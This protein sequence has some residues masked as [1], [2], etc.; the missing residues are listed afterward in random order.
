MSSSFRPGGQWGER[1]VPKCT[2][3]GPLFQ[4][5]FGVPWEGVSAAAARAL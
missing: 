2:L 1:K 4:R 5:E 3:K